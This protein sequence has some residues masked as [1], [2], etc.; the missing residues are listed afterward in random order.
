MFWYLLAGFGLSFL[1]S[2][3]L[4]LITL[5]IIERTVHRGMW[6]GVA[7]SLGA[8]IA[9]FVYTVIA[10]KFLSFF[11]AEDD[12]GDKIKLF[13]IFIFL[14]LGLWYLLRINSP[15]ITI[16][17]VLFRHYYY[18]FFK[19][20]IIGFMNLLIIPYWILVGSMLESNGMLFSENQVIVIF[21]GAAVAG[22]L[23]VFL[24]YVRLVRII[25]RKI[26]LVIQYTNRAVG[27]LFFL[28]ALFQASSLLFD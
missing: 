28:L 16:K 8:S 3:P 5:T 17:S 24:I 1:G 6:S 10:L 9:E 18:D 13:S 15:S 20:L 23:S 25:V 7:V 4:G 12:F 14:G 2:I 21:S 11:I 27:I 22:A 19:G 26:K